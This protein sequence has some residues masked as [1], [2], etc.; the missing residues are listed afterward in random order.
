MSLIFYVPNFSLVG[1]E[2]ACLIL[3]SVLTPPQMYLSV[4][5]CNPKSYILPRMY[6]ISH[7]K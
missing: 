7:F 3:G 5:L 6:R 1:W 4:C 2:G